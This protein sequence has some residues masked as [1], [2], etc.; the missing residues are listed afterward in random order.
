ML[1]RKYV[2]LRRFY[3]K[4]GVKRHRFRKK[5]FNIYLDD[6]KAY[7]AKKQGK[8][9][10]EV[11]EDAIDDR[12]G[13]KL[14]QKLIETPIEDVSSNDESEDE[15]EHEKEKDI[16]NRNFKPTQTAN[17]YSK[18]Q[19]D[20]PTA[21]PNDELIPSK[22]RKLMLHIRKPKSPKATRTKPTSSSS[23][24]TNINTNKPLSSEDI[25]QFSG[26]LIPTRPRHRLK[27]HKQ[28]DKHIEKEN[29]PQPT[30]HNESQK[31]PTFDEL[32]EFHDEDIASAHKRRSKSRLRRLSDSSLM[33]DTDE[34]QPG[35]KGTN[36]ASGEVN[37]SADLSNVDLSE[38][39]HLYHKDA[40][41]RTIPPA[42]SPRI[43]PIPSSPSI[44][45]ISPRRRL[46]P[47]SLA[48]TSPPPIPEIPS[49]PILA[50]ETAHLPDIPTP[51]SPPTIPEIPAI[52]TSH[53]HTHTDQPEQQQQQQQQPQFDPSAW[54]RTRRRKFSQ[55]H[56]YKTDKAVHLGLSTIYILNDMY[57]N[58]HTESQIMDYLETIY[59]K[60]RKE[61]ERKEI[62]Y[63]PF[64]KKSFRECVEQESV[65]RSQDLDLVGNSEGK[66]GEEQ[67]SQTRDFV[68]D[69]AFD[70][71]DDEYVFDD[72]VVD[73]DSLPGALNPNLIDGKRESERD[74][75]DVLASHSSS[76]LETGSY[77]LHHSSHGS[78]NSPHGSALDFNS[79]IL[80]NYK[81]A[82]EDS[83]S[84]DNEEADTETEETDEF[85]YRNRK[86][87]KKT[88]LNG[89]LPASFFRL[90]KNNN[91]KKPT[92][93]HHSN[94]TLHK[95]ARSEEPVRGVARK[96]AA[97]RRPAYS[98]ANELRDFLAPDGLSSEPE[99]EPVMFHD[100]D[101][102]PSQTAIDATL[103]ASRYDAQAH[104]AAVSGY[105]EVD[106]NSQLIEIDSVSDDQG[107]SDSNDDFDDGSDD[108]LDIRD[109]DT[110]RNEM[111]L[112]MDMDGAA[113]EDRHAGI[114]YML[115]RGSGSGGGGKNGPS[116]K[117]KS[118]S[119]KSGSKKS[120]KLQ[121]RKLSGRLGWGVSGRM[122]LINGSKRSFKGNALPSRGSGGNTISRSN[123]VLS[124]FEASKRSGPRTTK[125]AISQVEMYQAQQAPILLDSSDH[126]V[127]AVG[128]GDVGN[129]SGGSLSYPVDDL[130]FSTARYDPP[131]GFSAYEKLLDDPLA[132]GFTR[133]SNTPSHKSHTK[134]KSGG[135]PSLSRSTSGLAKSYTRP[136]NGGPSLSRST[137]GLAKP[138]DTPTRKSKKPT[139][140]TAFRTPSIDNFFYRGRAKFMG[141]IQVEGTESPVTTAL[142]SNIQ[143]TVSNRSRYDN[144]NGTPNY[145]SDIYT[146]T[147]SRLEQ[148]LYN[149]S[150]SQHGVL[151]HT[152]DDFKRIKQKP[153]SFIR[154]QLFQEC[155]SNDGGYLKHGDIKVEFPS[156]TFTLNDDNLDESSNLIGR[157][158]KEMVRALGES[159]SL[160]VRRTLD[161]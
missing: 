75:A 126:E 35:N 86:Y 95:R 146:S 79:A 147:V 33:S 112:D 122:S 138:T 48:P 11:E 87:N 74:D 111:A 40:P 104:T 80:R 124:R 105:N 135:G 93:S 45:P 10:Y 69:D 60:I 63:G 153:N 2:K 59:Q 21:I 44:R 65:Q 52:P 43:M 26:D 140:T 8:A 150:E 85:R 16:P 89:V 61:R 113:E 100:I 151:L 39:P 99:S 12:R 103:L 42:S 78:H 9:F 19:D 114:N 37:N 92:P 4:A 154:S 50:S 7:Q 119:K 133:E 97:P 76:S 143:N 72:E 17:N 51:S 1:N 30:S 94:L 56:I 66:A 55:E 90:D 32:F 118:G 120:R 117:K 101:V 25:F 77:D 18:N 109:Y 64:E 38:I 108:G 160:D 155:L 54:R 110:F 83:A 106:S 36:T 148:G 73:Q 62:G 88:A 22:P 142:Q 47:D 3:E 70:T 102:A 29:I 15:P 13:R 68:E 49:I 137:S 129:G 132:P 123:N 144:S 96:K 23:T 98:A 131:T 58:G 5:N 159:P 121:Q 91:R 14:Y 130:D 57:D 82:T 116:S 152:V 157:L 81:P 149:N 158:L 136:K 145:S 156:V 125:P 127:E 28:I 27:L 41:S 24:T 139:G 46:L 31:E 115:S 6:F 67:D 107:N 134:H 84:D 141:T 128:V 53:P 20:Q 71:S 161:S 34:Q